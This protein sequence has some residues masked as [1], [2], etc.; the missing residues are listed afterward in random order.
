MNFDLPLLDRAR[1]FGSRHHELHDRQALD[2]RRCRQESSSRSF[3][4]AV[5]SAV[6]Q[7]TT[8]V[9]IHRVEFASAVTQIDVP[10]IAGADRV[11]LDPDSRLPRKYDPHRS[12]AENQMVAELR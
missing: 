9:A 8:R 5:Q 12:D 6:M 7:G 10:L 1:S 2:G 11:S 3:V 4:G